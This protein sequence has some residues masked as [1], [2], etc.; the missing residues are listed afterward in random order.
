MSLL[1]QMMKN[2]CGFGLFLYVRK[3]LVCQQVSILLLKSNISWQKHM[4]SQEQHLERWQQ[5]R[6]SHCCQAGTHI[7]A[8]L[9]KEDHWAI[10]KLFGRSVLKQ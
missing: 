8:Q 5:G 3:L 4:L 6:E 2:C 7:G 9:L 10:A 1:G